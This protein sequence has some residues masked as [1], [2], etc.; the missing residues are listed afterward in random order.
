MALKK[1]RIDKYLWAIRVFK[2]R[3]LAT[4]AC[5]GGKVK[6]GDT[7]VK[8]SQMVSIGDIIEVKKGYVTYT[9][10][11]LEIIEKRLS[12]KL[13][14]DKFEDLTPPENKVSK[15]MPSVFNFPVAQ[16][17]QGT[18][19]PTKKERRSMDQ[20]HEDIDAWFEEE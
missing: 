7:K 11:A 20:L 12:A 14:A 10:K 6:I 8:A 19:R 9:Y 15:R 3:S 18:G 13:V 16:R 4:N 1:T 5:K 2:T 17:K